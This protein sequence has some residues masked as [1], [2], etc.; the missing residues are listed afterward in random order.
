MISIF[1]CTNLSFLPG[2]VRRFL[3]KWGKDLDKVVLVMDTEEIYKLYRRF[4]P[5]YFPRNE[6]EEKEAIVKLPKDTGAFI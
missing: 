2:T 4:L 1:H 5:L 3:E 6:E